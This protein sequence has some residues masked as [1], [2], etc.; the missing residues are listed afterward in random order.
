MF[1]GDATEI[2]QLKMAKNGTFFLAKKNDL[3]NLTLYKQCY[4]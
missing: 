4:W 2:F 3:L 1:I